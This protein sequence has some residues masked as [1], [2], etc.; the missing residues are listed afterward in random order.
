[1]TG[2]SHNRGS[3]GPGG[4]VRLFPPGPWASLYL[5]A[6]SFNTIPRGQ[7]GVPG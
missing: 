1:M 5:I 6:P 7:A 3:R 2:G 4:V